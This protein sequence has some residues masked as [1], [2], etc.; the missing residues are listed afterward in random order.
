MLECMREMGELVAAVAVFF[1][2]MYGLN[3][4]PRVIELLP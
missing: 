1:I 4:I 2:V 3:A